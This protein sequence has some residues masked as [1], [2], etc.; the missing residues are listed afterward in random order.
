[1]AANTANVLDPVSALDLANIRNSLMRMEDSIIFSLIE[2][3]Q[4]K[5]NL[6]VYEPDC[7]QLGSFKLHQLKSAGSNG[8]LGDWFI[9]Q[10]EC[11]HSQ[12]RRYQHPTEFSFFNPLPEPTLGSTSGSRTEKE[13]ILAEVPRIAVV[14]SQLLSIYR[15]KVVPAL[16]EHGDDGNHGSTAVQD[17]HVLQTIATRI[18]YGLFV[19][20]SK[21][22]TERE[23][24]ERLITSGDREGLMA[25]I[26]KP[27]VELKNIQ[28]VILK[29]RTFSQN[30]SGGEEGQLAPAPSKDTSYKLNPDLV[31]AVFRDYI[32][33]L[34][35]EVEV[36]YLLAR[37]A[38]GG[39][40][41]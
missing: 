35:K 8:C 23:K 34:T 2:R 18:Y 22:R 19:A 14:N 12:V 10:T 30:I 9:Y 5:A 16:C 11:L 40:A 7:S 20:E 29:A 33:P 21:F 3:S 6:A 24:A 31:G 4:Y 32:M 37:L 36:E 25:F 15:T 1:M 28:R 27:D 13:K 38:E 39:P 26:T 41:P 17:V